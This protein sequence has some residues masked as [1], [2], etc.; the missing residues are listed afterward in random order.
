MEAVFGI[1]GSHS[2]SG[3]L[4][5]SADY[6]D[7][8]SHTLAIRFEIPPTLHSLG[9]SALVAEL[10]AIHTGLH[11]LHALQLRG[12]VY[13]DCRSAVTKINRLWSPGTSFTEAGAALVSA[14]RHYLSESI[15]LQ[16]VKGHPERSDTPHAAWSRHQWGIYIA[17]GLTKTPDISTLPFMPLPLLRTHIIPLTDVLSTLPNTGSWVWLDQD[18]TP[19][20]GNLR[21]LLSHH[22]G[23]A[24][25]VNRDILR[26]LRGAP[27]IWLKSHRPLGKLSAPQRP[28]PLRSR[29]HTLRTLWDLRWHGE[30]QAVASKSSDPQVSAY[31]ICHRYWSQAHVLCDCP[32]T[33]DARL[34]GKLDLSISLSHLPSG[35]TLDLGRQF[36]LLLSEY[37]QPQLLARRWSGHWDPAALESLRPMIMRCTIKQIKAVLGHIGRI[38]QSATS[39]CWR[40]FTAM[41]RELNSPP[42]KHHP[43]TPLETHQLSTIDWDPRLGEDHG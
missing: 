16:W 30:N 24:Y 12:T 28:Q 25:R 36:K 38:T 31:P 39:A 41:A 26:S 14:S 20:L 2:G 40:Q 11:L 13:S 34:E 27:P 18:G 37:N 29:M 42:A 3:A 19:P 35:P 5:L 17:D 32:S 22:R 6:P 9:G 21:L 7:W 4:F 43:P 33:A 1:Q 23:L 15:S 8:C 10:L